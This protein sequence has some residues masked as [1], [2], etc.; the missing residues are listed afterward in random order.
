MRNFFRDER[1]FPLAIAAMILG[2]PLFAALASACTKPRT[3]E[4]KA[5][6]NVKYA[7]S[8]EGEL[9]TLNP[10]PGV[11]CYVLR[12]SSTTSTRAMSCVVLPNTTF[13]Q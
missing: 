5:D 7:E 1:N 13:G 12:G 8:L 4:E 11:E 6:L 10:R 3:P 9:V 2:M